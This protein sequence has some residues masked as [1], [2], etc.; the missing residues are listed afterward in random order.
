MI[1]VDTNVISYFY[2]SSEYSELAEQLFKK[3]PY[4]A[5]PILWRSEFRNVLSFYIRKKILNLHDA[6]S[7]F[8]EAATLLQDNEYEINSFQV[9]TLSHSSG[10]SAYDCEFVNLAQ[11]MDI[12]LV[13]MDKKIL[14]RFRETAVSIEEYIQKH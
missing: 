14:G 9:L 13:T 1:V 3:M 8:E 5:A 2:L 11:N 7:I 4:W 12:P 6:I 10:C